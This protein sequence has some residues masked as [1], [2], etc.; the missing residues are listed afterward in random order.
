MFIFDALFGFVFDAFFV[1]LARVLLPVASLGRARV[2]PR[3]ESTEGYP[4]S[5]VMR[6]P[7]G[8]YYVRPKV[9]G[10]TLIGLLV[11][12][13]IAVVLFKLIF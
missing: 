3:G 12:V 10:E 5:G 4:A 1:G 7:S 2:T 8:I 11:L 9:A 6:Q 13:F